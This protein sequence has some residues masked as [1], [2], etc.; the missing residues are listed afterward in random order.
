MKKIV[1]PVAVKIFALCATLF[2]IAPS[3]R[4]AGPAAPNINIAPQAVALMNHTCSV[5]SAAKAFSFHAEILFDQ[6]LPGTV[7]VQFAA[8]MDLELQRPDEIAVDYKSDLGAKE[9]WY[10]GN[11]LTIYDPAKNMYATATVPTTIDAMIDQVAAEKHLTIP[12]SDLA[13]S[14]PCAPFRKKVGYGAYIG[15]GDVNGV[16]CDHVAFSGPNA[17]VQLWLDRSGK[18]VPRK[19]VISY[20]NAPGSPEYIAVLS[21]WKFPPAIPAGRFAPVVPAHAIKIDFL[22]S[23]ETAR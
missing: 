9:I 10:K 7:K 1:R 19:I 13:Y 11:T 5:L 6:V 22:N 14:D 3:V 23:K 21:D 15:V 17:D 16:P 12:L 4:A 2:A 8:A 18:P 20:R